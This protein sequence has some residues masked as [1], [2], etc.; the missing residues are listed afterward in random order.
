MFSK[1]TAILNVVNMQQD[2]YRLNFSCS[3]TVT[4]QIAVS[5]LYGFRKY[6]PASVFVT[7]KKLNGG[8]HHSPLRQNFG[9]VRI[10]FRFM[11]YVVLFPS[12]FQ[13]GGFVPDVG[14][15][16]CFVIYFLIW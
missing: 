8:D 2:G 7:D 3:K 12:I 4:E 11:F 10:Y 15:F 1:E 16:N 13:A 5:M 6:T 9:V 14:Y